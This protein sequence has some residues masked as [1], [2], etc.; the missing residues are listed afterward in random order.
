MLLYPSFIHRDSPQ[1]VDYIRC[2][3]V[4]EYRALDFP[5]AEQRLPGYIAETTYIFNFGVDW[6]NDPADVV[7][8]LALEYV[9]IIPYPIIKVDFTASVPFNNTRIQYSQ[10]GCT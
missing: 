4:K 9:L 3:F 1:G 5:D 2:S 6:M 10:H 8:S 7:L